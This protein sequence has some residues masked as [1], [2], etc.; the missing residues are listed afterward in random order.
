MFHPGLL[1]RTFCA[2]PSHTGSGPSGC[3]YRG[4]EAEEV[5]GEG[6][7]SW[8]LCPV[9][10]KRRSL[11]HPLCRTQS[12]SL[13]ARAPNVLGSPTPST[14]SVSAE[15]VPPQTARQ[16]HAQHLTPVCSLL[17]G[18]R[19]LGRGPGNSRGPASSKLTPRLGPGRVTGSK[20]LMPV[21]EQIRE[22]RGLL[23]DQK[24]PGAGGQVTGR[25]RKLPQ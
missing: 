16:A 17:G 24:L 8:V 13:R 11:S 2:L 4:R 1:S 9:E 23:L 15:L 3:R 25:R 12:C 6:R 14:G 7:P 10:G 18:L 19:G 21:R 22:I 5:R 20:R